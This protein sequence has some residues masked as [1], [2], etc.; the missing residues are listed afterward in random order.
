MI[1]KAHTADLP[2]ITDIYN[3]AIIA[4]YCTGD[5]VCVSTE[6][7]LKWFDSHNTERTPIFVYEI[8]GTVIA[9]GYISHYRPGRQAFKCVGEVSYYVDFNY[10]AKGIGKQL[11]QFLILEAKKKDYTHLIAILLDCNT[12]S[13]T[14]LEK[15]GFSMWGKMP[16]IA[17]IDENIYSHLYYGLSL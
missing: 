17:R 11:L 4:R 6:E 3:Q 1:R 12:K 14:L 5:T 13:I 10:H 2:T 9:F 16:N 8:D 15:N 7:R